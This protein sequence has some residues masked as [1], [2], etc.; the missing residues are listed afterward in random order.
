MRANFA[1]VTTRVAAW[2]AR[3]AGR[4]GTTILLPGAQHGPAEAI[5]ATRVSV[6]RA[7]RTLA[8]EGLVDVEPGAVTVLAPELLAHRAGTGIAT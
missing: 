6:N 1:D 3:A 4:S 7:L 8:A 2:L 5:G